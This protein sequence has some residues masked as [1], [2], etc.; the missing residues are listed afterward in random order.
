M[1][2]YDGAN[3]FVY[4]ASSPQVYFDSFGLYKWP[5]TIKDEATE[6]TKK[7]FPDRDKDGHW[8]GKANAFRHC[9]A[10][11]EN[12]NENGTFVAWFVGDAHEVRGNI[13]KK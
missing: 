10:S 9:L 13:Q 1:G 5:G 3:S 4:A 2:L 11:C 6:E 8:N 12:S 7:R